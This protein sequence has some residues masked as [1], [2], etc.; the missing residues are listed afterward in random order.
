[1][2]APQTQQVLVPKNAAEVPG[3]VP[4]TRMTEEYV[5]MVGRDAFFWGWPMVNLYNR[6]LTYAKVPTI[7]IAGP[8]PAAPLN[9]LGML[10]DYIVPEER[11]VAC[12]NQDV[13]YGIGALA[14]DKSPVV[15]QV[16]D[17]GGRFWV[18]QIV[19]L[20][21]DSFAE[22]GKM[23]GSKPGFYL[24]VGPDWK[25]TVPDGINKVFRASTSTGVVIPRVFQE[26]TTEDKLAVQ[27]PVSQ[28]MM[29]PLTDFDGKMKSKDWTKLPVFPS[30]SEGNEEIRWVKSETFFDV[31][32][33]VMND[34]RPLPGE[35][36]L[37]AQ[38][39]S[40]IDAASKDPK[41]KDAL[42]Q[43]AAETDSD[44]VTPLF[45]FRNYGLPLQHHWTTQKN[46]ARFGTD[47]FSRTAVAKSN[48][49]VNTP[50]ET[51]YFY[52]D[53]DAKGVRLNGANRYMVTFAK[54]ALPPVK[55]F[56][57]L[58]LYNQHHFF[59]PNDL[60]RYSLGTKNKSLQYNADGSLTLHV[61]AAPP[62]DNLCSNWLPAPKNE[63]FTLYVRSY[64]PDKA[65]LDGTWT[66]PGVERVK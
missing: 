23:Y 50:Q 2:S 14:L 62:A 30:I 17:F 47:Y 52:Q 25:G 3:P 5:R 54:G 24:L 34:A 53:L 58:T 60:K 55:G 35:E 37:Y 10:T 11:L 42:T 39:R 29:Y 18:Y 16:P 57:S 51:T 63:D 15:V 6:R 48:I 56:W 40:M 7:G 28:I 20:R 32:P 8:A 66:P 43:V 61:Q 49:F 13:V 1:M 38:I 64:W 59:Q 27:A 12:P 41:L 45:Q 46:G 31:L 21:T 44:L 26:D 9:Q 22:L 4:G 65:I 33:A 36:A 19:D